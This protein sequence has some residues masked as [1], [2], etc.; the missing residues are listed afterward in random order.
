MYNI[1]DARSFL[2]GNLNEKMAAAQ[3]ARQHDE[4]FEREIKALQ[5]AMPSWVEIS[6][7]AEAG[8]RPGVTW[9]PIS[10][11]ERFCWDVFNVRVEFFY[12]RVTGI[13]EMQLRGSID[14]PQN[15]VEWAFEYVKTDLRIPIIIPAISGKM[16]SGLFT[17]M[18]QFKTP[19][20]KLSSAEESKKKTAAA[21]AKQ[22]QIAQAFTDWCVNEV[23]SEL[24][25]IYNEQLN[26]NVLRNWDGA[27]EILRSHLAPA[28]CSEEWLQLLRPY[29]LD[30]IW[31]ACVD[32]HNKNG[33]LLG[34]EVGLGKTAIIAA[35]VMMRKHYRTC[36]K[37][38]I[39]VKN[40][41]LLQF[42]TAFKALFPKAK[43]LCATP[44]ETSE[45]N[46][47]QFLARAAYW[48]WDAIILTHES[49][50]A[51]PV[52]SSTEMLYI[53]NQ[54]DMI[55]EELDFLYAKGET[56][57]G[58]KG[59]GGYKGNRIVKQLEKK[60][61]ELKAYVSVLTRKHDSGMYFEDISPDLLV[62]DEAQ[63]YKNDFIATKLQVAG[64]STGDSQRASD[65]HLKLCFLQ[66]RYAQ[67]F[68]LLSTGTP[69]PT[70]SIC[71]MYVMQRYLQP[72]ILQRNKMTCFDAWIS[73]FGRIVSA[74]EPTMDGQYRVKERLKE[75]VNL[76]ELTQMYLDICHIKRFED[77][78]GQG[79]FHRPQMK[80]K[81][82]INQMS[83][84]QLEKMD[85]LQ[86][87]YAAIADGNPQQFYYT[88]KQGYLLW[89]P[90]RK[91]LFDE[92]ARRWDAV[93]NGESYEETDLSSLRANINKRVRVIH[94]VTGM[95]MKLEQLGEALK[96]K[97]TVDSK[98]DSYTLCYFEAR[99]LM[100]A[101]QLLEPNEPIRD[102]DKI[103]RCAK[104]VLRWWR[105]TK[106]ER[107]TQLVFL[108]SGT[109]RGNS[110]FYIYDWIKAWLVER[111]VPEQ[112][113]Q[114]IQDCKDDEAK[115]ELFKQ[116][117]AGNV[118]VLIGSTSPMGIGVNV[119]E[120]VKVMHFLDIPQRPDEFEQRQGRGI[121]SGNRYPQV[122]VYQY[123]VQGKQVDGKPVNYG[124]DAAQF[125]MLE[126][127]IKMRQ[128][129]LRADPTVRRIVEEDDQ[130]SIY[131]MLVAHAT[132]DSK[133]RDYM[134][135]GIELTKLKNASD[136][137]R[138][139]IN[140]LKSSQENSISEAERDRVACLRDLR[141][142]EPEA[143]RVEAFKEEEFL[144]SWFHIVI[145]GEEFLGVDFRKVT[146]EPA[147][148]I[149]VSPQIALH[150]WQ[151]LSLIPWQL[152]TANQA[153][154]M[155]LEK[156]N[157]VINKIESDARTGKN[158][159]KRIQIGS[160]DQWNIFA[161]AF[162][163]NNAHY[164]TC[165]VASPGKDSL[166][167]NWRFG[168]TVGIANIESA[169]LN[170]P[171]KLVVI[172]K[173]LK[174]AEELI[175]DRHNSLNRKIAAREELAEKIKL[176]NAQR[177]EIEQ[178]LNIKS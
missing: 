71:G 62:I 67:G 68:L 131:M 54:L 57:T 148:T 15:Q 141:V 169:L 27:G 87:R 100:I 99:Q 177:R 7:I 146:S 150:F 82:V 53:Q 20:I 114:F 85:E 126:N 8:I 1:N 129:I 23:G 50:K 19:K 110:K 117:N 115:E 125:T 36:N 18:L 44:D 41:T 49:F 75:F 47:Q 163:S 124:A 73:N 164:L 94:P 21:I 106:E 4:S 34:L 172:R 46:R 86:N 136:L 92:L 140:K 60:R 96:L 132:G 158:N 28:G 76:P 42:H 151:A 3:E 123:F 74:P 155:A 39:V 135:L 176:L 166:Q 33:I 32:I 59:R 88:D 64:I 137:L 145:E 127:K 43:V 91:Q 24:E 5:G 109:P 14:N 175:G 113:I 66:S 30:A 107:A 156:L 121:R 128:S 173:Q 95:P 79:D 40:S 165:W 38:M 6:Q 104:R 70:N 22:D 58:K 31:R 16:E 25:H 143:E 171:K 160:I 90:N 9:I 134:K 139:E 29:Q 101:P 152:P 157:Y 84:F 103:V 77:V 170:I 72:Q 93:M 102:G 52:K 78:A 65:F 45:E 26:S 81:K 112:E 105:L 83:D 162:H 130:Q 147:S 56:A 12:S 61:N 159:G 98:L 119:Q 13:W 48:G 174:E 161:Q 120:R 55:E 133:V 111:G 35:A 108:D 89:S 122:L 153:R 97:L 11:Y 138:K 142:T 69:E 37:A 144:R 154:E 178:T 149:Q 2:S 167:W 168:K 63:A 118:R 10:Y 80:L 17:M 51:I 116:V